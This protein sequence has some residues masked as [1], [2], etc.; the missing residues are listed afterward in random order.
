MRHGI[1][2]G[3]LIMKQLLAKLRCQKGQGTVEYALVTLG[4]VV[5]LTAV[6]FG[7]T[8][9]LKTAITNAFSRAATAIDNAHS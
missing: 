7:T 1:K 5:I 9:P 6:L 2:G 8:N 3:K 4:I